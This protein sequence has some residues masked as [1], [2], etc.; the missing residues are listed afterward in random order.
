ML[1]S[2]PQ[3]WIPELRFGYPPLRN[4]PKSFWEKLGIFLESLGGS[5]RQLWI[6]TRPLEFKKGMVK[7]N[8]CRQQAIS[9]QFSINQRKPH[10]CYLSASNL[11]PEM[12]API[13]W[14]PGIFWFFLMETP[15]AHKTHRFRGV[16]V[17]ILFFMGMEI[18]LNQN[19]F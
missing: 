7:R 4:F 14:A 19:V 3:R 18:S 6:K 1:R 17:P 10:V 12:A 16:E 15:H 13:S 11:G 5:Q 2:E 8:T 9:K